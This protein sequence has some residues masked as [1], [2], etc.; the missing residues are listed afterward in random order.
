M[1]LPLHGR[2]VERHGSGIR[3]VEMKLTHRDRG[4]DLL[5]ELQRRDSGGKR[6]RRTVK[7]VYVMK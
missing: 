5:M 7:K 1:E 2:L 3:A 6:G 4:K